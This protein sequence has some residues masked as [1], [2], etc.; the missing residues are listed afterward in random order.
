M[1]TDSRSYRFV[2]SSLVSLAS[3]AVCAAQSNVPPSPAIDTAQS[4]HATSLRAVPPARAASIQE[5]YGKLPMS[6]E[7]NQGQTDARVKFASRG[8]GYSLFLT[9]SSA[10]LTL[11]KPDSTT[12]VR[13]GVHN[14]NNA[15]REARKPTQTDVVRMELVR[16]NPNA[17]V[18]GA[19]QLPGTANYFTGSEPAKWHTGVPTYAK[20]RYASVYDGV[21]LV[22]YGNQRQLE[23]D[24][25]VAPNA[26]PKPIQLHFTGASKL[27]LATNG[28]LRVQAK[29]GQ[30][31]FHKPEIYQEGNG[32]R[33]PVQ[34]RFALF[35]NNSVGFALGRYDRSQP[36]VIDP[37]LVYST[38]VGGISNS[39]IGGLAVDS[40]GNAYV[41]GTTGSSNYP[42]TSGAYQTTDNDLYGQP[43]AFVAK[44][45]AKGTALVYSTYL[46]GTGQYFW[47]QFGTETVNVSCGNGTIGT[48]YYNSCGDYAG[49]IAVDSSGSAYV[50]GSTFSTDFPVTPGA[51]QNTNKGDETNPNVFVT[52]LNPT[53]TALLYSTYLGG[54]GGGDGGG[55]TPSAIA[56]GSDGT[57]FVAGYAYS[58]NFPVT[59]NAIQPGNGAFV[60]TNAFV[61]RLNATGTALVYSTY[62]GG[63]GTSIPW[64]DPGETQP[65]GD[66]ANSLAVDSA[67]DAF[68]TGITYGNFPVTPG[69]Y[70]TTSPPPVCDGE[71]GCFPTSLPFVAK[72]NP[73]GTAL[74]YAT[75]LNNGGGGNAIA[76]DNA[77]SAYTTGG[78]SVTKLTADGSGLVY[79]APLTGPVE[80]S[81]AIAV[82]GSGNA[83]LTGNAGAGLPVT[84]NALQPTLIGT[85][86][87]FLSELDATGSTLLYSTY[88]GGSGGA[89]ANNIVLDGA[90]NVY[91]AGSAGVDFPVTPGALQT[92]ISGTGDGFVAKLN[93]SSASTTTPT[94]TTLTGGINPQ[95]FGM[96]DTFTATVTGNGGGPTGYVYFTV[97]G[98]YAARTTLSPS[99]T[100]VYKTSSLPLGTHN[101]EALYAGS[102]TFSVSNDTVAENVIA[103]ATPMIS[104]SAGKYVGSVQVS[105]SD[106]TPG[107][108]IYYTI[109]GGAPN[110]SSLVYSEPFTISSGYAVVRAFATL[111][112]YSPTAVVEAAYSIV[113]QTPAPMINPASGSVPVGQPVS[114]TDADSTATIRYTTNG[115]TP[116]TTSTWYHGPL[117]VLGP[118]TI[119]SIA[120]STG[121]A[122]SEMTAAAYTVFTQA[123][124]ILPAPGKYVGPTAIMLSDASPTPYA[125]IHYTL[126]GSNP[127]ATSPVYSGPITISSGYVVVKAIATFSGYPPTAITEAAYTIL[128]QN[129][130]PMIS[131]ASGSYAVGQTITI[132]D[133][134]SAATIRY[135]T[136]GSTPTTKSPIYTKALVLTGA[137]TVQ[138]I[139]TGTSNATSDVATATYTTE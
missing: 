3:F 25:V 98:V 107:A 60:A 48:G 109:N 40:A 88:L 37:I 77:G 110:V 14:P 67:G 90:G 66:G 10:V 19:D 115:S 61:T 27:S 74:V 114:I 52:K 7:A 124:I 16:A 18:S 41:A 131:P 54:T 58:G 93:L 36:L 4:A 63:G 50:A 73:T 64:Y 42:V 46:G 122:T 44:L 91:L 126:D 133:T 29:N 17:K 132:T 75:Y 72:L 125:T 57:A 102:P 135:T 104:P 80:Y 79:F 99:G 94:T 123:P 62:L 105:L 121:Q 86:D 120:T 2:A 137:E 103:T 5:S 15:P 22:Y 69:A 95:P 21:D 138:A 85:S 20:V 101:V 84:Q 31:A 92:G 12:D 51:F 43:T 28:D 65:P 87:A 108:T 89:S 76:V 11:T 13:A 9:G 83:Y 30:I 38:Y 127:S 97:D 71:N 136:D 53:G 118:E 117:A 113:P 55:D 59:A 8:S 96:P 70:L 82:D 129:P 26:D 111:D 39:G 128:A 78:S 24:F 139:A 23:Y 134:D 81:I 1:R 49:P 112:G 106:P 56:V 6:F 130:T 45:N 47:G 100:A 35:A 34:G 119:S 116:S 32:Q 33:H 68:V